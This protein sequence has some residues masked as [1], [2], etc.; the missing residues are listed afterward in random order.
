[1]QLIEYVRAQTRL[2][3][4]EAQGIIMAGKVY[5]NNAVCTF[6]KQ[7]IKEKDNVVI[8][9]KEK[10]YVTRAGLK[11][12]KALDSFAIDVTGAVCIDIGAAEGGFTDCMLKNQAAR[13]YA[14]DVAYGIFDWNLRNHEKVVVLERTNARYLET[15]QIPE[16]C[17]LITSD[18]SFISI[19]KIL[20]HVQTFLKPDGI[21]ISLFKP[22]FELPRQQLGKN[23][24]VEC[25]EH[26]IMAVDETVRFLS[27]EGI[28]IRKF[29]YSPI[30]G[31][32]G[33]IEFLLYG[34]RT[35]GQPV[36]N[37][38]LIAATVSE[39]FAPPV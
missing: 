23:G 10:K 39:A 31:N 5:L 26:I 19:K 6:G 36:I 9:Y 1:M 29:T 37:T 13:V 17:D 35:D 30:K 14:V 38:D 20:P 3:E 11:L 18:V 27:K 32:N 4:F 8:K 28:Y 21:I 7:E 15:R 12:E 33:N 2:D 22:Q 25:H 34:E 24:N 16:P